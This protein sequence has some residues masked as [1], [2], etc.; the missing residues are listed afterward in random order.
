[1]KV[2]VALVSG[3]I[4][5]FLFAAVIPPRWTL[6]C[7]ALTTLLILA[8][9]RWP[10]CGPG[11]CAALNHGLVFLLAFLLV[12]LAI[13]QRLAQRLQVSENNLQGEIT[14]IIGSL[15]VFRDD[16]VQ[17]I[18]L[19]DKAL[20]PIPSRIRV[21]WYHN[22]RGSKPLN[23]PELHAGERWKLQLVL[24]TPSGRVN[25]SGTDA[26]R[27]YFADGI[28]ALGYVQSGDN[29]RLDSP[30]LLS[31]HAWRESALARLRL[32][33]DDLPGFRMLVALAVA[34]RQLLLASDRITLSATGTGHLLAISGLH[35]GLA[36]V[37]GFYLGRLGLL[38]F[39]LGLK[40]RIAVALP[41]SGAWLAALS[42]AALAGFGISTQRALIM[43][44]VTTTVMLS[45]RKINPALAW[46]VAMAVVLMIDPFAPLRAGFWFSFTAVAVLMLLFIPRQGVMSWREKTI[47]AQFGISLIM[48]PLGLYWF[49]QV[50][51]PGLLANLIAIPVVSVLIVP[52]ILAAL[53]LLWVPGPLAEWLLTAAG[54]PAHWL[55]LVLGQ[56]AQFQPEVLRATQAP[57]LMSSLL[58]ML[59][60]VIVLLPRGVPGRYIGLLLMFPVLLPVGNRLEKHETQ[61]DFLDVG[62]GLATLVSS[63]DY[64][65]VYDTGPGNGLRGGAG[66]DMV[67]G[68]ILPMI[69]ATGRL[70]DMVVV[71]HGD[72]D[73]AGGLNRLQSAFP[74]TEYLGNLPLRNEGVSRCTA[75]TT[76]FAGGL[77]FHILHPTVGLPYLGNDSSCVI[78]VRGQGFDLLLSG[79]ISRVVEQRL[80]NAG[81]AA[82]SVLT[83][84][85]HGSATSSSQ[86][87]IDT[88]QPSLVLISSAANNRFGFPREEVLQRY[89]NLKIKTLNTAQ[90]GGIRV[91]VSAEGGFAVRSA[92]NTRKAIWRWPASAD[93]PQG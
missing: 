92:R 88:L 27:W 13:N 43:L 45:R 55:L 90:C 80:V 34:D 66:W 69:K 22:Q 86:L 56:L 76:W 41:W 16:V 30:S 12:T 8:S 64:L 33:A 4:A 10:P 82:H 58:G 36:A 87:L 28:G 84:P 53:P 49:Q 63:N 72:L 59:G 93:C 7:L 57:G 17:F 83:A 24:R 67:T 40:Q 74:K 29:A 14:G 75:P 48:A 91:R 25:F 32:V 68:T 3:A 62:Q 50:P 85:H 54:Y 70:P 1:M 51:L 19:P 73:H 21:S 78:S 47:T 38:F 26:E 46:L 81:L 37:M 31:L 2:W 89:R 15:P 52:P 20:A 35:I 9:R 65:M 5:P 6:A 77:A 11:I 71:S 23:L 61:I 44:T 42:Y 39:P 60:A 18:F 79:D